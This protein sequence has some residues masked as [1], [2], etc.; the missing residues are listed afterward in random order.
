MMGEENTKVKIF[1]G[2]SLSPDDIS[3][4][5]LLYLPIIGSRAYSIYMF[6]YSVLSRDFNSRI[7]D[8]QDILSF[9][10]IK[11]A[12][13]EIERR[14]LEAIP[15]CSFVIF[16]SFSRSILLAIRNTFA[17]GLEWVLNSLSHISIFSKES[18]ELI[19]YTIIAKDELR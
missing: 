7:M 18:L 6:F 2:E 5:S 9:F 14:K 19:A 3:V 12:S 16:L 15:P 11:K 4:L 13:F 1:I 17:S 10:N 8:L